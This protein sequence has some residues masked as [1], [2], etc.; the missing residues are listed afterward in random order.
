MLAN[1]G[2]LQSIEQLL[3]S[4]CKFLWKVYISLILNEWR[5]F[6]SFCFLVIICSMLGDNW[7]IYVKTNFLF[8]FLEYWRQRNA[9][10][11]HRHSVHY[12]WLYAIID[13]NVYVPRGLLCWRGILD[14]KFGRKN[15]LIYWMGEY[16]NIWMID[17]TQLRWRKMWDE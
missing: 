10:R 1:I 5:A 16:Y 3:V 15:A 17:F 9:T 13:S 12:I 8:T 7:I 14:L 4:N 11:S 2:M 6:F